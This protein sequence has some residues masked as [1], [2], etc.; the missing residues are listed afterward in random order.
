METM[1]D[2]R[3]ITFRTHPGLIPD[4]AGSVSVRT[5]DFLGSLPELA[6]YMSSDWEPVSHTFHPIDNGDVLLTI[7]LNRVTRIPGDASSLAEQG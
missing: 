3:I 2:Y 1:R 6:E 4:S 5:I 7:L